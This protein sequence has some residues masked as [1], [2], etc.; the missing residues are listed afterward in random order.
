MKL[1]ESSFKS[2]STPDAHRHEG[3]GIDSVSD[4]LEYFLSS[5][6]R[7]EESKVV[8]TR[9]KLKAVVSYNDMKGATPSPLVIR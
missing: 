6:I 9:Q 3:G 1:L 2:D 4:L 5:R 8:D 7:G